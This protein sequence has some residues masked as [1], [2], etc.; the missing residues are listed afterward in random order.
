M[1]L[2]I[3]AEAICGGKHHR[4]DGKRESFTRAKKF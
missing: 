4:K 2:N 3:P 1:G